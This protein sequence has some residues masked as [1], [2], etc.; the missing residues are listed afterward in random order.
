[1][2]FNG[3]HSASIFNIL[4]GVQWNSRE[5]SGTIVSGN[6]VLH[7]PIYGIFRENMIEHDDTPPDLG[8]FLDK[9]IM[10]I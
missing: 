9:P 1:M 10:M 3:V 6:G 7:H 5:S 4:N 2:R 8:V